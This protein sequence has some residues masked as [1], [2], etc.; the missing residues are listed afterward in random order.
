MVKTINSTLIILPGNSPKNKEW[1]ISA[2]EAFTPMFNEVIINEYDHWTNGKETIDL[3]LE[4]NKLAKIINSAS[5]PVEIFAKSAGTILVL[6]A[7]HNKIIDASKIRKCVFVGFPLAWALENSLDI[8]TW[9]ESYDISTILIQNDHDPVTSA[10]DIQDE[11]DRG[12]FG[13]L[14]L[15]I[16]N[17]DDHMYGNF[18]DY[19]QYMNR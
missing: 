13:G 19:V 15:I 1:A 14:E 2:R 10:V 7:V 18:D 4:S 8:S 6:Y 17:G 12:R 9:S 5:Q 11:Q 3:D 16:Q